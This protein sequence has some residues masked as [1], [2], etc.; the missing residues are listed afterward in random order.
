[1]ASTVLLSFSIFGEQN[2]FDF[3]RKL[4]KKKTFGHF[5]AFFRN[6]WHGTLW[7]AAAWGLSGLQ[8]R[9][10]FSN[11]YMMSITQKWKQNLNNFNTREKKMKLKLLFF[12]TLKK[13]HFNFSQKKKVTVKQAQNVRLVRHKKRW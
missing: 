12:F 3:F 2:F 4:W 6:F 5:L 11:T 13:Q 8:I 7:G 9:N 1:M 10:F